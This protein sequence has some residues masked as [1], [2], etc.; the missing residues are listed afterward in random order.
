VRHDAFRDRVLVVTRFPR[1]TVLAVSVAGTSN[2]EVSR[3]E[4]WCRAFGIAEPVLIPR[5]FF[6]AFDNPSSLKVI[7]ADVRTILL[8]TLQ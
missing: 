6:I 5:T 7:G 2:V 8:R 3:G 1:A 4:V